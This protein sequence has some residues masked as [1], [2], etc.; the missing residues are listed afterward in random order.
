MEIFILLHSDA[1]ESS[2]GKILAC[3]LFREN[4]I[5]RM[6]S[7]AEAENQKILEFAHS[8]QPG[9]AKFYVYNAIE[10][11]W[12]K[13]NGRKWTQKLCIERYDMI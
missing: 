10:D 1:Y 7:I 2:D 6:N 5:D 12:A 13:W 9:Q 8:G 3:S 11:Y 4:L